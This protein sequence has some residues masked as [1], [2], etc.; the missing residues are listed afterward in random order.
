[1]FGST[2]YL[3]Y[4]IEP[5]DLETLIEESITINP[6]IKENQIKKL[7]GL[8]DNINRDGNNVLIYGKFKNTK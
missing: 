6:D 8:L 5:G 7:K 1:M 4:N 3:V 2:D